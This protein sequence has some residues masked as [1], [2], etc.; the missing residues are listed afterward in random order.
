MTKATLTFAP[1]RSDDVEAVVQIERRSFTD[2]WSAHGFR[3]LLENPRVY[4]VCAREGVA[5]PVLGYV[6]AW[7]VA[8]EGEIANLAVLPEARGR[9]V[10][11]LLL[12][13]ALMEA[14]RRGSTA[15]YLEVRDSNRTAR[16]LYVS[17]GF[18]AVGR[19]KA[20]YRKPVEDAIVLRRAV[21]QEA[22]LQE[23]VKSK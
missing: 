20:Y 9:G 11:G 21:D 16:E 3:E 22:P 14:R 10:G 6:V 13:K 15:M 18:E 2:P 1:A 23:N 12:D 4:F 7:F 8:D 19:R 17:R 5:G